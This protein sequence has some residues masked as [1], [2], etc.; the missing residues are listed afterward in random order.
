MLEPASHGVAAE[1]EEDAT[2]EVEAAAQDITRGAEAVSRSR[3]CACGSAEQVLN[4]LNRGKTPDATNCTDPS[5]G[6]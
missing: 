2:P 5:D 3:A 1:V 4:V 6:R